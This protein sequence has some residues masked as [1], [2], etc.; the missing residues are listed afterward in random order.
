M[1]LRACEKCNT[2]IR[3]HSA[4]YNCGTYKGREVINVL[5]KL[6]KKE[7]KQKE[8]ELKAQ[9]KEGGADSA[10]KGPLDVE[11]LSRK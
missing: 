7:R 11:Q 4:C 8:K 10:P 2:L 1:S 3:P 6:S 5:A 9:E